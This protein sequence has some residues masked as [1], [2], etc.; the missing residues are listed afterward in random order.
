MR[1]I[2]SVILSLFVLFFGA[3][4]S[5]APGI[6]IVKHLITRSH[7][8]DTLQH[9]DDVILKNI[10]KNS[11]ESL[12]NRY[13]THQPAYKIYGYPKDLSTVKPLF[14][15]SKLIGSPGLFYEHPPIYEVVG[16][17]DIHYSVKWNT[18]VKI[19]P[20]KASSNCREKEA[21]AFAES[22]I[23]EAMTLY[24]VYERDGDV[25]EYLIKKAILDIVNKAVI[26]ELVVDNFTLEIN[27]NN[28]KVDAVSIEL[29]S[30]CGYA[31]KLSS[32][33]DLTMSGPWI[34]GQ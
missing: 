1:I 24:S 16:V 9:S 15:R 29:F 5:A 23:D 19:S 14:M 2:K 21:V 28:L 20:L 30:A 6:S 11:D 7:I 12:F 32:S 34:R 10:L 3:N 17:D 18:P 22:K 26:P 4:V 27:T 13:D 31:V 8:D 33:G 25:P